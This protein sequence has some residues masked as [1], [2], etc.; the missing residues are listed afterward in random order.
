MAL[1][2]SIVVVLLST[3]HIQDEK[4]EVFRDAVRIHD[5]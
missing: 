5:L 1:V 4:Y 2:L 3:K